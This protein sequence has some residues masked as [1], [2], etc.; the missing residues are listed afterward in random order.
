MPSG[1]RHV[2][3]QDL[4]VCVAYLF[5]ECRARAPLWIKA[6]RCCWRPRCFEGRG[7]IVA[8]LCRLRACGYFGFGCV[9]PSLAIPV[10][11]ALRTNDVGGLAIWIPLACGVLQGCCGV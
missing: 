6:S 9:M 4:G 8:W 5:L 2:R 10:L 3:C 11:G 1:K 7:K